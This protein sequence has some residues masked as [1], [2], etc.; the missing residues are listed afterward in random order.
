MPFLQAT[1]HR[2]RVKHPDFDL[3]FLADYPPLTAEAWLQN[4]MG[5]GPKVAASALNASTLRMRSFI[6]DTHVVR[7]LKRL[8]HIAPKATSRQAHDFV[9]DAAPHYSAVDLTE[10]HVLIKTLGQQICRHS[11]PA[12]RNCPV[13]GG[14]QSN[15]RW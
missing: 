12:C 8:G 3:D 7:V 15:G 1:L 6:A 10:L 4:L 9:M 5:V 14:C 11:H 2:I 13:R